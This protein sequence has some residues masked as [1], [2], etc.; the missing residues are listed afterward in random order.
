VVEAEFTFE[1]DVGGRV[2]ALVMY[3]GPVVLRTVRK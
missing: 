3:Q 2:N 1:R